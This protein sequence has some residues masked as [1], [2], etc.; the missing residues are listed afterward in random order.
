MPK[1]LLVK[2]LLPC[3]MKTLSSFSVSTLTDQAGAL[4]KPLPSSTWDK[5]RKLLNLRFVKTLNSQLVLG[6]IQT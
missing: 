3:P 1:S 2:I 5:S 4:L 6:L